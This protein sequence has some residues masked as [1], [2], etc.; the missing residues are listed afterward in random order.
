MKPFKADIIS[1]RP[2]SLDVRIAIR[3]SPRPIAR[4]LFHVAPGCVFIS[5]SEDVQA[6]VEEFASTI[7]CTGQTEL[8]YPA[9]SLFRVTGCALKTA[10]TI[11]MPDENLV[12]E[13]VQHEHQDSNRRF[14]FAATTKSMEDVVSGYVITL[15]SIS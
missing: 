10:E 2:D 11:R 1:L 15:C 8:E 7:R 3:A 13:V 9:K 14:E 5:F 12:I 4:G 6:K